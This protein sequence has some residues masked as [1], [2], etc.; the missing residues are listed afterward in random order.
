M[1][2]TAAEDGAITGAELAPAKERYSSLAIEQA[3][4][5]ESSG[6]WFER[7]WRGFYWTTGAAL[8]AA[9][10]AL[11]SAGPHTELRFATVLLLL[12]GTAVLA[13]WSFPWQG[14][15]ELVGV[16]CL[17]AGGRIG[18]YQ[19]S[20]LLLVLVLGHAAMERERRIRRTFA[21][22]IRKSKEREAH[23]KHLT[24]A[25]EAA[26]AAARARSE[27]LSNMSHEIRTPMTA[28]LGA[29]EL[30]SQTSL[31]EDQRRYLNIV[32]A[33]GDALIDL[34]ND[35]LDLARLESGRLTIQSSEFNLEELLDK[36]AEAM[37]VRA[38]EK[39]LELVTR[40]VP[41]VPLGLRG[42]PRR[43]RQIL[44]NLAGNAIK[45]TKRGEI[46]IEVG[47]AIRPSAKGGDP[48]TIALRFTVSDTGIGIP[49]DKLGLIFSS[50]AQADSSTARVYDGAGLGLAIVKRLVELQGGEITVQSEPGKGSRFSFTIEFGIA[51]SGSSEAAAVVA[52][53]DGVSLVGVRILV[54]ANSAANRLLIKE[55]LT[56]AGAA[57]DEAEGGYGALAALESAVRS[58]DARTLMLLDWR[59]PG[60]GAAELVKQARQ[61]HEG[62]GK[63]L[64]IIVM[65]TSKDPHSQLAR[66]RELGIGTWL[67]K[68][69]RRTQLMKAVAQA[70]GAASDGHDGAA[71]TGILGQVEVRLPPMRVLLAD[72]SPVNR[73]L[74]REFFKGLPLQLDEAVDGRSAVARFSD[75]SYDL[76]LMDI[77]MPVMDGYAAT[78]AIRAWERDNQRTATPII[79]LTAS[80]L[81][82]DAQRCREA[83]CDAHVSK[84]VKRAALLAAIGGF[85]PQRG[86]GAL[87]PIAVTVD[88]ALRDLVPVF[89][90]FKRADISKAISALRRKDCAP[91]RE[92]G[93][94]VK[95]EGGAYG[96]DTLTAMGAELEEAAQRNDCEAALE[97]AMRLADYLERVKV[98][99]APEATTPAK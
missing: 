21:K 27:F 66:V 44:L 41:D 81:E 73:M 69:I 71:L 37:A 75:T 68:P 65:L 38:H 26:E 91:A 61:I 97:C 14:S 8:L 24:A 32:R 46:T 89:L 45:F 90:D 11:T 23:L 16:G 28:V 42:D 6:N 76:V 58:G 56:G 62:C 49:A 74:V 86:D 2:N 78:R 59:M 54:A 19:W 15:L 9:T 48:K 34:I 35:I 63:D 10:T 99:Y 40:V 31:S 95:G 33:S 92:T 17:A 64:R 53:I 12:L 55:S 88:E 4:A 18:P 25:R 22:E 77:R 60:I 80:A 29:A 7:N 39:G 87:Q 30:L 36:L 70:L 13:P 51:A 20:M 93:H 1:T 85:A 72:D 96:F 83:G 50:L 57:V 3:P 82:E 67:I 98:S 47:G 43:L 52:A 5:L 84:P 94:Q 79:A